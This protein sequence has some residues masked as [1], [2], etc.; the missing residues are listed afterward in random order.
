MKTIKYQCCSCL[1]LFSL[2]SGCAVTYID[3]NGNKNIIGF[4]NVKTKPAEKVFYIAG[5]TID[6]TSIGFMFFNSTEQ[7]SITIGYGKETHTYLKNNVL[8]L[9][10]SDTNM[11]QCIS[12]EGMKDE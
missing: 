8:L 5:E 12:S 10:A 6:V 3:E 1:L 4:V 2:L 11:M 7:S 9:N